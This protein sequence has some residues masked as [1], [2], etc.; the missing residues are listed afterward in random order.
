MPKRVS[1]PKGSA[2][3]G[4]Y[5]EDAVVAYFL[6]LM[7]LQKSPFQTDF[8]YVVRMDFQTETLGWLLDDILITLKAPSGTRRLSVSVKSNNQFT[9]K[10]A[11]TKFVRA[12]WQQL[13]RV[14]APD[15]G[16]KIGEDLFGVFTEPHG[17]QIS[18]S[19]RRLVEKARAQHPDDLE[20][21][22][23]QP[24]YAANQGKLFES[25]QCPPDLAHGKTLNAS[26]T[27]QL[28]SAIVFEEFD[29]LHEAS[30][31]RRIALEYCRIALRSES[32]IEAEALWDDLIKIA[33]LARP[34]NG[35]FDLQALAHRIRDNHELKAF[36]R[37]AADWTR[38]GEWTEKAFAQIPERI[39]KTI[40]LDRQ[41]QHKQI[42]DAVCQNAAVIVLG[43]SGVGKS[44]LLK[45]C[46]LAWRSTATVLWIDAS[47]LTTCDLH[48]FEGRIGLRH[49]F[50][51]LCSHFHDRSLI[52]VID[53]I[54][55]VA[56]HTA[57]AKVSAIVRAAAQAGATLLKVVA[58]CQ[59]EEW[60]R[61]RTGLTRVENP[62]DHWIEV[63]IHLPEMIEL[64]PIWKAFPTLSLLATRPHL[65]EI[66]RSPRILDLLVSQLSSGAAIN[67]DDWVG[68][69]SLI[70]WYWESEIKS[71][72]V[73]YERS[74]FL[75]RLAT[76]QADEA[77]ADTSVLD[78][79]EGNQSL[80]SLISDRVCIERMER[81]SFYHDS[82]GDWARQKVILTDERQLS[83][84]LS[85]RLSKPHWHRAIRLYAVHL[86]ENSQ[87]GLRWADLIQRNPEITDF[88]LDG[89]I[90]T[91]NPR[92]VIENVW[93]Q[94]TQGDGRLLKRFLKRFC[95][96][97][98]QPNRK[99]LENPAA[100][101]NDNPFLRTINRDPRPYW[102]S[103]IAGLQVFRNHL[104]D[105]RKL[106]P[107]ESATLADSWLCMTPT[108]W[109]ERLAAAEIAVSICEDIH[110]S[111]QDERYSES[112]EAT[113]CYTAAL[114]AA[115]ELP[116]RV[117]SLLRRCCSLEP[118]GLTDDETNSDGPSSHQ[119]KRNRQLAS[120][121]WLDGPFCDVDVALRD[122][123]MNGVSLDALMR[124]APAFAREMLLA[125]LIEARDDQVTSALDDDVGVERILH[126]HFP[127]YRCGP[128]LRFLQVSPE[129]GMLTIIRLVNHATDRW[130]ELPKQP[131]N[132]VI[133]ATG[134]AFFDKSIRLRG[135]FECFHW[136]RGEAVCN[137]AVVSALMALEKWLSLHIEEG[138]PL[139][140][141]V[142]FIVT[143][144]S[145]VALIGMLVDVG[146][147]STALFQNELLQ[148]LGVAEFYIFDVLYISSG[149]GP[150]GMHLDRRQGDEYA[151]EHGE[152][153]NAS[154][155]K[156]PLYKI[157]MSLFASDSNVREYLRSARSLWEERVAE[158]ADGILR[159]GLEKLCRLFS[160]ESWSTMTAEDGSTQWIFKDAS[161]SNESNANDEEIEEDP[162][163]ECMQLVDA[164]LD[165]ISNNAESETDQLEGLWTICVELSASNPNIDAV[166]L[167]PWILHAETAAASLMMLLSRDWLERYPDRVSWCESRLL[168]FAVESFDDANAK[169]LNQYKTRFLAI[170]V[171]VAVGQLWANRESDRQCR[172]SVAHLATKFGPGVASALLR[173][174]AAVREQLKKSFHQ[175]VHFVLR[176]AAADWETSDMAP[177]QRGFDFKFEA[178]WEKESK[179]FVDGSIPAIFPEF[180][181]TWLSQPRIFWANDSAHGK[182]T[183]RQ[184]APMT[185]AVVQAALEWIPDL[186]DAVSSAESSE[187]IFLWWQA[188]KSST[189]QA[190]LCDKSG[191]AISI[192]NAYGGQP[193]LFD[194]WL[195]ERISQIVLAA[196]DIEVVRPLWTPIMD[197]GTQYTWW[198]H[199]FLRPFVRNG[200]E[201]LEVDSFA[202]KWRA[203]AE[204][205]LKLDSWLADGRGWRSRDNDLWCILLAVDDYSQY[206][207]KP[208]HES[209]VKLA[210]DWFVPATN[211]IL[212]QIESATRFVRWL[213]LD[214]ARPVRDQSLSLLRDVIK[215]RPT[216]LEQ[217]DAFTNQTANLLSHCWTSGDLFQSGDTASVLR[218]LLRMLSERQNAVAMDLE[219]RIARGEI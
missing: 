186:S 29:F 148:V 172:Y 125:I 155:R 179:A 176:F 185:W 40:S 34:K 199:E 21:R 217:N 104:D 59:W 211:H 196:E 157:A 93:T 101:G 75:M 105:L 141:H 69:S 73:G 113:K 94:L 61:V 70:N 116:D 99:I 102:P 81:V 159:A 53:G 138:K 171:A 166:E 37:Y 98:S 114:A 87:N 95:H 194:K 119:R 213:R 9:S 42:T 195:F 14:E 143:H 1:S 110:S 164:C 19:V 38:V 23:M 134:L 126:F 108:D 107:I 48:D 96:I 18:N 5:F 201:S 28:L 174:T 78:L 41:N 32:P 175:L 212:S 58:S 6:T 79:P 150:L 131:R 151:N 27:V 77:T 25:F 140:E 10:S 90:F 31:D 89:L 36:P 183:Y 168:Q 219:D 146:R 127:F 56:S 154:F 128:F 198:V 30:K 118:I 15:P 135:D 137:G 187:W 60:N 180:D 124:T 85:S 117:I 193:F 13:F 26:D 133:N 63:V 24:G 2:G 97:A 64:E 190:R 55:R 189:A 17:T 144:A 191:N 91:A 215:Q 169:W 7:L 173:S 46:V 132:Q 50:H 74:A 39:G 207:W 120:E 160:P 147:R 177:L 103:W 156:Q 44:V 3:E 206:L 82:I 202:P 4:F 214:V 12:A 52:L 182:P 121:R 129:E 170:H 203:I 68:E 111:R 165:A 209:L 115:Q 152:W 167:R 149:S 49:S 216:W 83:T 204:Y 80:Q 161:T 33:K 62:I 142:S 35:Y 16:F 100:Q 158:E 184:V 11:P 106:A 8:G 178:W 88:L 109:P 57:L 188:V 47:Q 112:E 84:F 45:R 92:L 197:L 123:C 22:L 208:H 145:S 139:A 136:N 181:S 71:H 192:K 20:D 122:A 72:D 163:A 51:D 153:L 67:A 130:C 54:D 76:M 200:L 66:I 210:A 43:A 162:R 205:A 65:A 218:E 86:L